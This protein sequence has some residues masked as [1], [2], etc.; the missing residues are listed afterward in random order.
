MIGFGKGNS[1]CK[2]KKPQRLQLAAVFPLPG[3]AS[4]SAA[5]AGGPCR[6]PLQAGLPRQHPLSPHQPCFQ[7]SFHLSLPVS[8]CQ[9]ILLMSN[10]HSHT[11]AQ[12]II[13]HWG[14]LLSSAGRSALTFPARFLQTLY[15]SYA[16]AAQNCLLLPEVVHTLLIQLFCQF[17]S[18]SLEFPFYSLLNSYPI[19]TALLQC[20]LPVKSFIPAGIDSLFD[21]SMY[22][23]VSLKATELHLTS[24]Y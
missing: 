10:P 6:R 7:L 4:G 16:P 14:K 1:I 8:C 2:W 5:P 20:H 19:L 9:V 12:K 15:L 3:S 21:T 17:C 13:H 22:F 18:L 11:F 23:Q 24:N